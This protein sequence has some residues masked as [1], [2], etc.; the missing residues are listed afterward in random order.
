MS[1]RSMVTRAAVT[2]RTISARTRWLLCI[3]KPTK[4]KSRALLWTK[5]L[6]SCTPAHNAFTCQNC[7]KCC[8]T[9]DIKKSSILL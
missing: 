9:N 8:H 4:S 5:T 2:R 3:G 7:T 1:R 6:E